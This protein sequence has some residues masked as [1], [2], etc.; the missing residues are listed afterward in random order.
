[1]GSSTT[2][3]PGKPRAFS[4]TRTQDYHWLHSTCTSQYPHRWQRAQCDNRF[5]LHRVPFFL[6]EPSMLH[7]SWTTPDARPKIW[8][9]MFM[10]IIQIHRASSPR[11]VAQTDN[12]FCSREQPNNPILSRDHQS[13]SRSQLSEVSAKRSSPL[14]GSKRP[15]IHRCS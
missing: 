10:F 13:G 11:I 8:G 3:Q 6:D 7:L 1:M 14:Y 2:I 15:S 5:A 9:F 12:A 4:W